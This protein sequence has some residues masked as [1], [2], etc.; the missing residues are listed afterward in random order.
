MTHGEG[1]IGR[2]LVSRRACSDGG[3]TKAPSGLNGTPTR[4]GC[5][6]GQTLGQA[7]FANW[8][9]TN[10]YVKIALPKRSPSLLWGYF[11]AKFLRSTGSNGGA[12]HAFDKYQKFGVA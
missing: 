4:L 10:E 2:Y 8:N 7:K 6:H 12:S 1:R 3:I 9:E 5:M 11:S